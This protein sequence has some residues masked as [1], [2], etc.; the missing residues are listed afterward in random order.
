MSLFL[1]C[2]SA[3]VDM[4]HRQ[5]LALVV[6]GL[7]RQADGQRNRAHAAHEHDQHV[8]QLGPDIQLAVTPTDRPTVPNA[9]QD[10]KMAS[11]TDT[12]SEV[13]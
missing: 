7:D 3:H 8:Q 6:T 10:S 11:M 5:D 2:L 12:A 4:P 1:F 13:L 9:E